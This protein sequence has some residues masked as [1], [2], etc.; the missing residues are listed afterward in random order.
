MNEEAIKSNFVFI[1]EMLDGALCRL[2]SSLRA[3]TSWFFFSFAEIVDFGYPQITEQEVL[4]GLVTSDSVFSPSSPTSF[5]EFVDSVVMGQVAASA[6]SGHSGNGGAGGSRGGPN[7]YEFAT[8]EFAV[9]AQKWRRPGIKYKRNEIILEVV[10]EVDLL[11]ASTGN[12]LSCSVSG[13]V[14]VRCNL[15]GMPECRVGINERKNP[16]SISQ[17]AASTADNNPS[18]PQ[19]A[20]ALSLI[21]NY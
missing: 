8:P 15:S 16:A 14:N 17:E 5:M 1:Y 13:I 20:K 18:D 3:A 6:S 2:T 12:V 9:E 10:E 11:I 4:R 21:I 7:V 19:Y